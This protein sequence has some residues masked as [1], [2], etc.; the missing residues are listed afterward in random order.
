MIPEAPRIPQSRTEANFDWSCI[1]EEII[2]KTNI[3]PI[4]KPAPVYNETNNNNLQSNL[5]T[6]SKIKTQEKFNG[7][8]SLENTSEPDLLRET[9][10]SPKSLAL[11]VEEEAVLAAVSSEQWEKSSKMFNRSPTIKPNELPRT[12]VN[13][14]LQNGHSEEELLNGDVEEMEENI[15]DLKSEK[16]VQ[17]GSV[18]NSRVI[19]LKF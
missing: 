17:N 16:I 10:I 18:N 2:T 13:T 11:T 4:K 5:L 1:G 19:I 8:P 14:E 12:P 7:T 15:K 9:P 3:I 6:Q